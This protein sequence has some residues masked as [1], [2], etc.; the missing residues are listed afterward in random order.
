MLGNLTWE[1]KNF[2]G[3]DPKGYKPRIE[4]WPLLRRNVEA[5]SS[6]FHYN[7]PVSK[8]A[9][10]AAKG[11]SI[12]GQTRQLTPPTP[13][14][15]AAMEEVRYAAERSSSRITPI[16]NYYRYHRALFHFNRTYIPIINHMQACLTSPSAATLSSASVRHTPSSAP[17]WFTIANPPFAGSPLPAPSTHLAPF[18][19]YH[20]RPFRSAASHAPAPDYLP[21]AGLQLGPSTH[22]APQHH[23]GSCTLDS[24]DLPA[25]P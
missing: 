6:S 22:H 1:L 4:A 12:E 19:R 15:G 18:P 17:L 20:G 14:F 21:A 7:Q 25:S 8:W 11:N 24:H 16:L 5:T 2:I 3:S 10:R 13:T 23:S 9:S